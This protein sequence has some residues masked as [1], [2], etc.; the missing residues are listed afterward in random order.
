MATKMLIYSKRILRRVSFDARLFQ[1][2]LRKALHT[3]SENEVKEL[4]SWVL[5]HFYPLAA[6]VVF[7]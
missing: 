5:K 1:K 2:E 3:L 7:A 4:K 6:P